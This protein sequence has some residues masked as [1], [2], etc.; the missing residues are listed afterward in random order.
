MR[1][2][3]RPTVLNGFLW[4]P[5]RENRNK[6][7]KIRLKILEGAKHKCRFCGHRAL[8]YMHV[9]HLH[10]KAKRQPLLIAVCVACHA[11]LHLGRNLLLGVLEV[12]KSEISQRE[13][14]RRTRKGVMQG[15]SLRQI[16]AALPITRGL[17]P[18]R[19]LKWANHM[20]AQIGN[21][22]TA[23]LKRPYCA[24]FVGLKRW[25]IE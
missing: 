20:L 16:K 7:K 22:P 5:E 9:H 10:L 6:W 3:L 15:K 8:K 24:V 25:Q 19:S 11:V 2:E 21:R 18:P 23:A 14:V 13:I 4:Y 12:W 1:L 17:F